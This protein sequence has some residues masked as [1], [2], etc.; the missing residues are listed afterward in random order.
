M[1]L[2][3]FVLFCCFLFVVGFVG[4]FLG[5]FLV[6]VVVCFFAVYNDLFLI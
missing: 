5:V 6:V 2:L 4:V 3:L 1:I